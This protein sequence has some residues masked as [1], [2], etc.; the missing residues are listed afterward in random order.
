[1]VRLVWAVGS[2]APRRLETGPYA[3][4]RGSPLARF[5]NLEEVLEAHDRG[6]VSS[7]SGHGSTRALIAL[8]DMTSP[9]C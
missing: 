6:A 4:M 8:R 1:V 3:A 2:G 9:Y 7:G 5:I